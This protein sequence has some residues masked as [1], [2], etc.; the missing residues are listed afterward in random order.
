MIQS[1]HKTGET[2][3]SS[4]PALGTGVRWRMAGNALGLPTA[5]GEIQVEQM[6]PQ[7]SENRLLKAFTSPGYSKF[8]LW[9][10][11]PN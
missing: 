3:A 1:S 6:K 2:P 9:V 11:C 4:V 10:A 8:N 7:S 5:S